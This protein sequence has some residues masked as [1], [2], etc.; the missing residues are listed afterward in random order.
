M[1]TN[2]FIMGLSM[3]YCSDVFFVPS[4]QKKRSAAASQGG[5]GGFGAVTGKIFFAPGKVPVMARN[6][7]YNY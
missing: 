3:V 4:S 7:S 6:T 1:F 2:G 5:L